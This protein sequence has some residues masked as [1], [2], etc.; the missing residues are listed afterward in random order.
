MPS[1]VLG[2]EDFLNLA[3]TGVLKRVSVE[4][5]VVDVAQVIV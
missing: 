3:F 1:L 5:L 4:V 2:L